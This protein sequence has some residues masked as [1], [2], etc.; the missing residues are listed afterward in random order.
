[1]VNTTRWYSPPNLSWI[2]HSQSVPVSRCH[3]VC[4]FRSYCNVS[5]TETLRIQLPHYSVCR[6]VRRDAC[7]SEQNVRLAE[8]SSS[9]STII[10]AAASNTSQSHIKFYPPCT[11]CNFKPHNVESCYSYYTTHPYSYTFAH[12]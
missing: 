1:M 10:K 4:W 3:W 2:I 7:E 12:S 5:I 11:A 8:K 6:S 9:A